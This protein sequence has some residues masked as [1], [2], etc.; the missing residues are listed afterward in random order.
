MLFWGFVEKTDAKSIYSG[1]L[2][3]TK[4][5]KGPFC[6]KWL[7]LQ[8]FLVELSQFLSKIHYLDVGKRALAGAS[9]C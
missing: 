5:V 7:T 3:D 8:P 6:N 2:W 1:I 9:M 4:Y